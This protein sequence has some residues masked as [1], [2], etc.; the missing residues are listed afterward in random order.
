MGNSNEAVKRAWAEP[1]L[2]TAIGSGASA[3]P[4]RVFA[5]VAWFVAGASV[6]ILAFS[7][8]WRPSL[9]EADGPDS[10]F[11]AVPAFP[12][13]ASRIVFPVPANISDP[14]SG[15]LCWEGTGVPGLE[16]RWDE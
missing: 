7:L 6:P 13:P 12:V 8:H 1:R 4:C 16:D 2:L 3:T 10:A 5:E 9:P 15:L 11:A 14:V